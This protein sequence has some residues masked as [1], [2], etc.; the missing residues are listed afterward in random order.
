[1]ARFADPKASMGS[2]LFQ[3]GIIRH[4]STHRAASGLN[5]A[6]TQSANLQTGSPDRGSDFSGPRRRRNSVNLR[7]SG[8]HTKEAYESKYNIL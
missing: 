1:M 5:K 4:H 3:T 6:M 2:P 8:G 7:H